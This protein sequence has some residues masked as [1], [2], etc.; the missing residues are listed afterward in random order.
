[1]NITLKTDQFAVFDHFL[2]ES[3]FRQVWA[4]FQATEFEF[5]QTKQWV[6]VNRLGDGNALFGRPLYSDRQRSNLG[7]RYYPAG[8]GFDLVCEA[9]SGS[10]PEFIPW[11][12]S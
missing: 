3:A 5:I 11:I 8:N 9:I 1:M 2:S 4:E 10:L 7:G 12:G 6:K